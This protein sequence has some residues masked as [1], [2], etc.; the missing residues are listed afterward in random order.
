MVMITALVAAQFV[1]AKQ[2]QASPVQEE[3]QDSAGADLAAQDQ[4][5]QTWHFREDF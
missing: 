2:V 4:L 1:L 5:E 3:E